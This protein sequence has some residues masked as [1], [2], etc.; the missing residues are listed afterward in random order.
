MQVNSAN[1]TP[2]KLNQKL[3]ASLPVTAS[4]TGNASPNN[5][6][7]IAPNVN[8]NTI[9]HIIEATI[10]MFSRLRYMVLFISTIFITCILIY[11]KKENVVN[12]KGFG[13]F[14]IS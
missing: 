7:K 2:T 9:K 4:T 10:T 5:A 13:L 12:F 1:I 11:R 3:V 8:D 6:I 14:R